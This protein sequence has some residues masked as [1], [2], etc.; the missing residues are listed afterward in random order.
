MRLRLTCKRVLIKTNSAA[1]Q[2]PFDVSSLFFSLA[3]S[4]L[5]GRPLTALAADVEEGVDP[6]WTL[7]HTGPTT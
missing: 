3:A 2:I 1:A 7:N 4:F 5:F 6:S